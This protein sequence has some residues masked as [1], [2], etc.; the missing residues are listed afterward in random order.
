MC[1]GSAC[2]TEECYN[3]SFADNFSASFRRSS[4]AFFVR[5]TLLKHHRVLH[6]RPFVI[7]AVA[8][9]RTIEGGFFFRSG[10]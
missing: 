2:R 7:L 4:S 9:K 6:R 3:C 5:F 8:R 10:H 1:L